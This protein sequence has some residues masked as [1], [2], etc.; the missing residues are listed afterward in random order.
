M[1]YFHFYGS[2]A[3]DFGGAGG[4]DTS[5]AL[6]IGRNETVFA[7]SGSSLFEDFRAVGSAF[8]AGIMAACSAGQAFDSGFGFIVLTSCFSFAGS[9]SGFTKCFFI[10]ESQGESSAFRLACS[11]WTSSTVALPSAIAVRR[12]ATSDSTRDV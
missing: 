2:F 3:C 6:G 8:G 4:G 11:H 10:S 1:F 7:G 9:C 5:A 12:P